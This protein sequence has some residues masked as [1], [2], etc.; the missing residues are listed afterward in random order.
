[1]RRFDA[2]AEEVA[3]RV[4]DHAHRAGTHADRSAPLTPWPGD[5]CRDGPS[6]SA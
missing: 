1:M 5:P 4:V 6:P 2:V 3:A